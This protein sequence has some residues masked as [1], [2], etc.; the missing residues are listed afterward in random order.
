MS[1][2]DYG[3]G[4]LK[5]LTNAIQS[6]GLD[7]EL[8]HQPTH[9]AKVQKLIIPGV[10]AFG[11][12]MQALRAGGFV[13]VLQKLHQTKTPIL[14]ICLGMQL[15]FEE[16]EES[17]G[18]AGLGWLPGKVVP[19]PNADK[20]GSRQ[21]IPHMGWND[22]S[23]HN[24]KSPLIVGLPAATDVYFVHSYYVDL[25]FDSPLIVAST[26]YGGHALTAMV[27]KD[28]LFGCQFHPEK[29]GEVGVRILK[30]FLE[31]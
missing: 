10:G 14:G 15:L 13:E 20:Q 17:P 3:V 2:L 24:P 25:Q 5:S 7:Y 29:S 9:L 21:K 12:G 11:A 31:F 22:L 1:V 8:V 26:D 18:E 28:N 6:L 16:S 23:I 19:I 4:N 27:Q 30:N